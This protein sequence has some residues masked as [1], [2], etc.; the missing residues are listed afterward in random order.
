[1]PHRVARR[2]AGRANLRSGSCSGWVGSGYDS[3]HSPAYGEIAHDS[4]APR[5]TRLHEIIEDRIRRGF[6]EDAAIA[7]PEH[8][9]LQRFQLDA[10]VGRHVRDADFAEV[11]QAGFRT[12]GGELR[13]ADRDFEVAF[14]T[15]IRKCLDRHLA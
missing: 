5:L 4:H 11:W 14:R 8:V 12:D 6:E 3:L 1:M 9:V 10:S 15:W 2:H 13:A 7:K